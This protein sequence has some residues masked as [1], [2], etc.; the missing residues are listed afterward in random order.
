MVCPAAE[1]IA[2]L[3]SQP[4]AV[5]YELA[6]LYRKGIKVPKDEKLGFCWYED[7]AKGNL[8]KAQTML[9]YCI[10]PEQD[11]KDLVLGY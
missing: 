11:E 5:Q 9:G 7:A 6:Q 3:A 2:E 10:K 1:S 4:T 8:A